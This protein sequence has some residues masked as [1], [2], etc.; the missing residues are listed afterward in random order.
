[1]RGLLVLLSSVLVVAA[2]TGRDPTPVG[3]ESGRCFLD[4]SCDDGLACVGDVCVQLED[5]GVQFDSGSDAGNPDAGPDAD[6]DGGTDA[7]QEPGCI[8]PQFTT[9]GNTGPSYAVRLPE[10]A[11]WSRIELPEALPPCLGTTFT[12]EM[13]F[14]GGPTGAG[15]NSR[16]ISFLPEGNVRPRI[17]LL[18][19]S[20]DRVLEVHVDTDGESTSTVARGTTILDYGYLYSLAFIVADD[21][22]AVYL[23]GM[24]E[25]SAS[26][27][28]PMLLMPT[29]PFVL[30]ASAD[31]SVDGSF[32]GVFDEIRASVGRRYTG[33]FGGPTERRLGVDAATRG[34]WRFDGP[35]TADRSGSSG[36]VTVYGGCWI[37]DEGSISS[38]CA[39]PI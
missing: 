29:A 25:M 19:H 6:V 2:C 13:W 15:I 20:E 7:G 38:G 24:L 9:E 10:D 14:G 39:G 37:D 26:L 32:V 11:G 4:G 31:D 1:M 35:S 21:E 8:V 3:K 22:V 27:Q 16:L 33:D 18:I 30:G 5:A 12:I 28:A 36:P 23:W 34:L 17:E